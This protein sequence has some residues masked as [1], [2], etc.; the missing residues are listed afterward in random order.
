MKYK[1]CIQ[2]KVYVFEAPRPSVAA[3][4]AFTQYYRDHKNISPMGEATQVNVYTE[5]LKTV[6][7]Y[8]VTLEPCTHKYYT[9]RPKVTKI[10]KNTSNSIEQPDTSKD[11]IAETG[12]SLC[13]SGKSDASSNHTRAESIHAEHE[14]H[15]TGGPRTPLELGQ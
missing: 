7:T 12:L 4:K 13:N 9:Q 3:S 10:T 2:H 15:E 11:V 6:K 14:I 8:R 1:T 5:T